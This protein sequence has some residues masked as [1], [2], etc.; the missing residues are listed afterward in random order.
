VLTPEHPSFA[1]AVQYL[2]L[3]SD[4]ALLN[5]STLNPL[6]SSMALVTA[7]PSPAL[8]A[9]V[10]AAVSEALAAAAAAPAP[11]AAPVVVTVAALL[12][13]LA[14]LRT[15][16][17][18]RCEYTDVS[19]RPLT[20]TADALQ[21]ALCE[22]L[23]GYAAAAAVVVPAA[24]ASAAASGSG[25]ATAQLGLVEGAVIGTLFVLMPDGAAAGKREHIFGACANCMLQHVTMTF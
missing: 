18:Q 12:Q 5:F 25:T 15:E 20:R 13:H 1:T 11:A 6:H 17:H 14:A 9:A 23:P 8:L 21:A 7:T 19:A 4:V 2:K 24:T 10:P 22:H 16:A 3:A